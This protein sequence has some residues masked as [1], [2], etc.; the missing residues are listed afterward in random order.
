MWKCSCWLPGRIEF[1]H[2][3][4]ERR[5]VGGWIGCELSKPEIMVDTFSLFSALRSIFHIAELVDK[6]IAQAPRQVERVHAIGHVLVNTMF[7]IDPWI[8]TKEP[9]VKGLEVGSIRTSLLN[10]HWVD[11]RLLAPATK[12]EILHIIPTPHVVAE[13]V[14]LGNQCSD[15]VPCIRLK[16]LVCIQHQNPIAFCS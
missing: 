9:R 7:K 12:V 1:A 5:L 2:A 11:D 8:T 10:H 16:H 3:G 15:T 14:I 6:K 13:E 4:F